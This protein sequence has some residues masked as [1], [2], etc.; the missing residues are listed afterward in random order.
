ME[1]SNGNVLQGSL[2]QGWVFRLGVRALIVW[3][4]L[5]NYEQLKTKLNHLG[6]LIMD[7][8]M[9]DSEIM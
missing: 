4:I 7:A 3:G 5:L 1:F 2:L 9:K 8:P 6:H